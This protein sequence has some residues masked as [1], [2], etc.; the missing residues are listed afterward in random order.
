MCALNV[1]TTFIS[2]LK[3]KLSF[4]RNLYKN[5]L[6][7]NIL[8]LQ[9]EKINTE[10]N[11]INKMSKRSWIVNLLQTLGLQI[12]KPCDI[13][14]TI[15]ETINNEIKQIKINQKL[16]VF[17]TI[18]NCLNNYTNVNKYLLENL[19]KINFNITSISKQTTGIIK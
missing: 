8:Q 3:S 2:Y 9:E 18:N 5:N 13:I 6:T 4:L 15:T 17:K 7:R 10:R 16:S 12:F 14:N 19:I 11:S 1:E